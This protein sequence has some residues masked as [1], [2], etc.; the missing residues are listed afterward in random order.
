MARRLG[1]SVL[2]GVVVKAVQTGSSA[3]AAGISPGDIIREVNR[4]G[5]RDQ[6]EL[7]R[8]LKALKPGDDLLILIERQDY[9]IYVAM[10]IPEK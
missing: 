10:K 6:K 5:V 7:Q 9:A 8:L 1:T 4:R 3:E 2:S